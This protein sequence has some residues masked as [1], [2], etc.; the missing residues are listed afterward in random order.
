[1]IPLNIIG[2]LTGEKKLETEQKD[3][4]EDTSISPTLIANFVA[5]EPSVGQ[6][7]SAVILPMSKREAGLLFGLI[8]ISFEMQVAGK[9]SMSNEALLEVM[10]I[11]ELLAAKIDVLNGVGKNV[12]AFDI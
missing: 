11:W 2:R 4:T 12:G 10:P 3:Q 8:K 9:F 7:V 5:T 6:T 1:M